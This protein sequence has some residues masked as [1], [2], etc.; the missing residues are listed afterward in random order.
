MDRCRF[1]HCFSEMKL[2]KVVGYGSSMGIVTHLKKT[3]GKC[4]KQWNDPKLSPERMEKL[5][6]VYTKNYIKKFGDPRVVN[7]SSLF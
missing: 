5:P 3:C 7:Q 1:C 6:T 2:T 4:K